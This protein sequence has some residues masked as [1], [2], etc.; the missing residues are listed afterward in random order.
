VK[1]G[2]AQR[3]GRDDRTRKGKDS[4]GR[5][6]ELEGLERERWMD[7]VGPSFSDESTAPGKKKL[8]L[9]LDRRVGVWGERI[10]EISCKGA[11]GEARG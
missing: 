11:I 10:K 1:R 9:T 7:L 4:A 3:R 2:N 5:Q 8:A 6:G